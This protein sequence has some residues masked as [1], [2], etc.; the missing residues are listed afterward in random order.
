MAFKLKFL[1][2]AAACCGSI[3]AHAS[4]LWNEADNGDLA[5]DG[6]SP[7]TLL[8]SS[9]SNR[10]VGST[11]NS[12]SGVDRDYF[13]FT[14]PT[15]FV[16]DAIRLLDNTSVSGGSSFIAIQAGPQLTVSTTGAGV[17]NLLGFTHYGND[18]IGTD[19]LP[20]MAIK[21]AGA[22]PSGVY[23]IWVQET[24]GPASYGLD[25]N[26]SAVPEPAGCA[27]LLAGLG[28]LGLARRSGTR[29]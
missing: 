28:L 8:V 14:V 18:L 4:V 19:L 15:G 6:L 1:A 26:I 21:F 12:G 7:T 25:L 17:E 11:G 22:L 13:S 23:S 10:I 20:T 16:L 2:M 27:M 29:T 5:N 3:G 9:G 24:G